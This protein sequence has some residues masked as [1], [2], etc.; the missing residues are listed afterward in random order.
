[1]ED[2][3]YILVVKGNDP[4]TYARRFQELA[5]LCPNTVPN[6][7]KLMEVFIGGLP[8]SIDGNVTA[9]KPQTLE[10]AIN[11]THRLMDHVT[12]HNYV[13]GTIDHKRKF[14]DSR[15]TDNNN[16]PNDRNNNKHSNNRNN[17]NYQDNR[18]NYN[19][20]NDYHQQHNRRQETVRAYATTPTENK[21]DYRNKRHPSPNIAP[22]SN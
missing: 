18:N 13:Q 19:R 22:S 4:K 14:D 10:E 1:M 17:N 21:R 12:K 16:Y 7:E 15:N 6:N 5:T 9:S 11:I 3:F 2:E 8:R 20:N